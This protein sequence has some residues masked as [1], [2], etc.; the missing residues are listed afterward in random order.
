MWLRISSLLIMA[1]CLVAC[2]NNNIQSSSYPGKTQLRAILTQEK[3]KWIATSCTTPDKTRYE[4]VDAV[5]FSMDAVPLLSQS[6]GTLFID[7]EGI[8]N[9]QPNHTLTD[10]HFTVKKI[11]RLTFDTAK[12]CGEAD[13]SKIVVR[14]LGRNPLWFTSIASKGLVLER[15]NQPALVL[16]YVVERLPGGQMNFSTEANGQ[17]IELWVAP[18]RCEDEQTGELYAMRARL[19]VNFQTFQGCG[20][21]GAVTE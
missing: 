1:L 5:N 7:A 13:Y 12:G 8:V 21:L 9:T 17:H 6:K 4:L 14:T 16:P 19:T 11:N 15:V 18:E 3:G 10:S 20:Y 2:Q